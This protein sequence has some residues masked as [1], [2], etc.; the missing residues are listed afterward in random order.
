MKPSQRKRKTSDDPYE[1]SYRQALYNLGSVAIFEQRALTSYKLNGLTV[2]SIKGSFGA[3]IEGAEWED[4][5]IDQNVLATVAHLT[6]QSS[7][8]GTT[9]SATPSGTDSSFNQHRSKYSLLL[10]HIP[11]PSPT[12]PKSPTYFADIR[13]A[14]RDLPPE[15]KTY[16]RTLAVEHSLWHSRKLASPEVYHEPA[17]EE[18]TKKPPSYHK[19][20]HVGPSGEEKLYLTAHTKRVFE[21]DGKKVKDS[22][23]LAWD[24]IAWCTQEK[25]MFKA[26]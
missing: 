19:P 13:L 24:L 5:P 26:K 17:V 3:E 9:P 18:L 22:Q 25:Y 1:S 6:S 21:G 23:K 16:L 7:E 12:S 20:V 14:F 10:S 4:V 8:D 11:S 2:F 15:R